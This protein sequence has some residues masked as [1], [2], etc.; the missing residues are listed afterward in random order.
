ML[1][2]KSLRRPRRKIR[3]LWR[4]LRTPSGS[5]LMLRTKTK[6]KRKKRKKIN[7][8]VMIQVETEGIQLLQLALQQLENQKNQSSSLVKRW[9]ST[10]HQWEVFSVLRKFPK[11]S[12]K[13]TH[14]VL[15]TTRYASKMNLKQSLKDLCVQQMVT[16]QIFTSQIM[17][18]S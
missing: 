14:N 12:K 8:K 15:F 9:H 1:I 7:L 13:E 2:L 6:R 16:S 10:S 4:K 3:M 5:P 18:T 17:L 11:E